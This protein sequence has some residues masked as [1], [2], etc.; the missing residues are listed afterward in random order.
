MEF[1]VL[2]KTDLH[3]YEHYSGTV[4]IE[5][6][7]DGI[8]DVLMQVF[9]QSYCTYFVLQGRKNILFLPARHLK[10]NQ[11]SKF[12]WKKMNMNNFTLFFKMLIEKTL[13]QSA[14]KL[15]ILVFKPRVNIFLI[16]LYRVSCCSYFI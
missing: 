16:L 15:C 1:I 5:K 2:V 11:F 14:Q 12:F 10:R 9:K 6:I 3:K 8:S 7:H 13:K 4:K